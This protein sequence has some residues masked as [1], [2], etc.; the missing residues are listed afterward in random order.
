MVGDVAVSL[1]APVVV[2]PASQLPAL[3]SHASATIAGHPETKAKLVGVTGTNGKTSVTTILAAL[4]RAL[5]WNAES[6]GTLTNERTTPAPPSSTEPWRAPS[7]PSTPRSIARWSP[8]RCPATR[9]TSDESRDCDSASPRSPTFSHDHLD[10][11]GTM[12]EYFD[13]KASLFTA[14]YAQRA[15][16]WTDDPYG[17]RLAD[18]TTLPVVRVGRADAET[19]ST[20]LRGYDILLARS[21]RELPVGGRLQRRQR[22]DG[23]VHH[24]RPG[25][26]RRGRRRG[27]GRR[28]RRA[29]S[30]RSDLRPR[31]DRGRRLRPHARRPRAAAARRARAPAHG[32]ASSRSLGP[33]ATAIAKS[34]PRWAASRAPGSDLTIVTSDNP[35]SE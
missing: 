13:A 30:I 33:A 18:S 27:D 15:V 20:S 16:I 6:I 31:R 21:P 23:H 5:R 22:A 11:H 9:S 32:T 3:L 35:R 24:E 34:V 2:V 12:E 26:G 1:D 8:S 4:A 19:S 29:R 28:R 10:Y 25:R 7:R 14:E 17:G